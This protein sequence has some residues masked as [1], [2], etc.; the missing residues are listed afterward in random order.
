MKPNIQTLFARIM[1]DIRAKMDE[2]ETLYLELCRTAMSGMIQAVQS[3]S[4]SSERKIEHLSAQ[5]REMLQ[6]II[7]DISTVYRNP[8]QVFPVPDK[9][10]VLETLETYNRQFEELERIL[11]R[12]CN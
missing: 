11:D 8:I 12:L 3:K 10:S 1:E 6:S 9:A 2:A 7:R 5:Y 4:A